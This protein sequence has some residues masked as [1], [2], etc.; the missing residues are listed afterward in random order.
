MPQHTLARPQ[1][2]LADR[3]PI[4][5]FGDEIAPDLEV[6]I[7]VLQSHGVNALELRTAWGVNVIELGPQR[8]D[9][10]ARLLGAS[11]IVVSAIGS[12]VGKASIE[13]DFES[14]L[15]RLRAAIDAAQRLG[16]QRIRVF[17]FFIPDCRFADFRYEGL[18]RMSSLAPEAAAHALALVLSNESYIS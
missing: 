7:A 5:A 8:L 9:R 14:D 2:R 3:W 13:D 16:T 1:N 10:A 15:P 17:S 12:P 18:R 6:Q 4:S 11:G